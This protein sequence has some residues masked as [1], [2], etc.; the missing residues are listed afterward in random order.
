MDPLLLLILG[1]LVILVIIA[2]NGFFVA[3]EFAYMSVDRLQLQAAADAGDAAAARAL[4]VTRRTSFMLSGAQLGI[5][6]TGLLVG[7]VA[8][9]MVG[10]AV[11]EL[12][13]GCL[14][15][16]SPSPRD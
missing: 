14:L 5:T 4:Q 13:G 16:T 15:Y 3:Q 6:V 10:R 12:L 7:Y 1:T 11:T 9:P 2:A 8:E